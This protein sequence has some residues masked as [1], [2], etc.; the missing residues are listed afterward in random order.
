[1]RNQVLVAAA[2]A[3]VFV[4]GFGCSDSDDRESDVNQIVSK[5]NLEAIGQAMSFHMP[6]D[7]NPDVEPPSSLEQLVADDF[8]PP[9][10]L[11]SPMSGRDR[12]KVTVDEHGVMSAP[13][14]YIY[15][16][17]P[18]T[19]PDTLIQAYEKPEN[20]KD[21]PWGEGTLVLFKQRQYKVIVEWMDIESF[22]AALER[23]QKWLAE[24][25][26]KSSQ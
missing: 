3:I 1:M 19:A 20:Y 2:M 25:N 17:L 9:A 11:I 7:N 6:T 22:Q 14:D 23:T 8:L 15:I 26:K 16:V 18:S 21:S 13:S 24:R 10:A 4:L 12:D 5:Y